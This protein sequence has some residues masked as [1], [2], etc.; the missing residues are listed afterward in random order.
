MW[1]ENCSLASCHH[2][3]SQSQG[4]S[5]F[6]SYSQVGLSEQDKFMYNAKVISI[7]D[8]HGLPQVCKHIKY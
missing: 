7:A 8:A 1:D 3:E 6:S 2:S 5:Q 4:G